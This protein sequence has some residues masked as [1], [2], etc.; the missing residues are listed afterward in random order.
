MPRFVVVC[1]SGSFQTSISFNF[2]NYIYYVHSIWSSFSQTVDGRRKINFFSSF[3]VAFV[4]KPRR[5]CVLYFSF[6][7]VLIY[8][9]YIHHFNPVN[10]KADA[11]V[12]LA[13]CTIEASEKIQL[14]SWMFSKWNKML[15]MKRCRHKF[16]LIRRCFAFNRNCC[17]LLTHA[18][19][20]YTLY[21]TVY[22]D[23]FQGA[24]VPIY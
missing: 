20:A 11:F 13:Q 12:V 6:H 22:Y 5:A 8:F 7:F 21:A 24:A 19:Y 4:W 3:C 16:D 15:H 2:Q 1:S 9:I 14:D 17:Q 18:I 10:E 23:L